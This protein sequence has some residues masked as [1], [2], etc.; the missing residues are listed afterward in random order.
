[1]KKIY[2]VKGYDSWKYQTRIKL[3]DNYSEADS[4]YSGLTDPSMELFNY[5]DQ[6]DLLNLINN[7]LEKL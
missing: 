5:K 3:F 7:L 2:I 6:E 1:M 4:F